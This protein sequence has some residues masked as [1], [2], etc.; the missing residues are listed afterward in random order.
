MD[1]CLVV[2]IPRWEVADA[3]ETKPRSRLEI[4]VEW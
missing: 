4:G 2:K 3:S 1:V